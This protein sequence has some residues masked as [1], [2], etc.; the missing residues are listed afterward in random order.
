MTT[1]D[2]SSVRQK[3]NTSGANTQAHLPISEIRDGV[4][5]LKNGGVR[6]VLKVSSINFR[7]KSEEEQNAIISAYQSF[8]NSLDFP[9]QILIRSRKLDIDEYLSNL[10]ERTKTQENPVIQKQT[11]EYIEY[12]KKLVEYAD[13]MEKRFYVVVPKN[14]SRREEVSI[15]RQFLDA[16]TPQDTLEKVQQRYSEFHSL[17]TIV[18]KNADLVFAGLERCGLR[19]EQLGTQDLI[20]LFY[21]IYNPEL[22]RSQKIHGIAEYSI[23]S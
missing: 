14:P 18:Q 4:L 10:L 22:S 15:W 11:Q 21:Q 3:K 17:K 20:E 6:I 13:I 8:L 7:L 19:V 2:N 1:N 5:L 23:L 9:I 12:V 16:I